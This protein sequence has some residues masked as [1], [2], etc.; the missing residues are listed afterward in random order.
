MTG[1]KTVATA[2]TIAKTAARKKGLGKTNATANRMGVQEMPTATRAK[3]I[4][5]N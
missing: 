5:G 3:A 4:A 1:R 2:T